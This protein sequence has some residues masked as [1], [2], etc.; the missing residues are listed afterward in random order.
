MREDVWA[1]GIDL[2]GTKIEMARVDKE[3]NFKQRSTRPTR[4]S[5]SAAEIKEEV[6]A[7][8]REIIKETGSM[9]VGIGL[10]VAGQIDP[11]KGSVV[12]SPN[13]GWHNEP[14]KKDL[15]Q[16]LDLPVKIINDVRAATLGEWWHG[17]GRGSADLVCLFVGT[18]I[19]GGV[20]SG[21]RILTGDNNCAAE[22]GHI[23]IDWQGPFCRCGNRGCLEAL[24]GGWAIA[25]RTQEL[26]RRNPKAG[27]RLLNFAQG[28]IEEI[29]AKIV[30][31][32]ARNGDA[33][34]CQVLSEVE[35][36]LVAGIVSLVNAFNPQRIILGGGVLRG[37]PQ[38]LS[39]LATEVKKYALKAATVN[40]EI[41]PAALGNMAGV[42]GAA[43][44]MIRER[45]ISV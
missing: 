36:A 27:Q 25:E 1:I 14:L 20:V 6:I 3:G 43:S 18:G 44:L 37:L 39:P 10:G 38:L 15:V 5:R 34:S 24:A 8:V 7:G 33:L 11:V 16:A 2:G 29:D 42:I 22:L 19:G 28:R 17:T 12:F 31:E 26:I 32:A 9:P 35:R 13:L 45:E 40:L 23:T 30:A 41:M 4:A 21:G